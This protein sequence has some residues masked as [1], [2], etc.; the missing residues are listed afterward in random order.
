[1]KS[2]LVA[3][4]NAHKVEE[5]RALL[6]DLSIRSLLE[7]PSVPAVVEDGAT[8]EENAR[9]KAE[10]ISRAFGVPVLADDS[11]LCV[12]ALD[13]APGVYSARYA[14]GTDMKRYEKLLLALRE[15]PVSA[16]GARFVCVIAL[17]IPGATTILVRGEC[18]GAIDTAPK[19]ELGFGYDPVF[20]VGAGPRTMAE[21]SMEEKNR[22]SHRGRALELIRPHLDRL[23]L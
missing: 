18:L 9:K 12:D 16:R 10:E 6:P 23:S 1:M 5:L 17:A 14:E 22:I 8:F 21:L 7:M 13:G 15:V 3:T 11:G 2:L 4:A 19:G 20:I